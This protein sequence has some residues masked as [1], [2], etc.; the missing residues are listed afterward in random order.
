MRYR[1]KPV[2]IEAVRVADLLNA[3]ENDWSAL[4]DWVA[5]AYEKGILAAVR[6]ED[7]I[8]KTLEGDHLARRNDW[9]IRGVKGELYPC[10]PEVFELTYEPVSRG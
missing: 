3:F 6:R 7:L 9:L 5:D 4:P 10:K 2:E 1:K 8:V